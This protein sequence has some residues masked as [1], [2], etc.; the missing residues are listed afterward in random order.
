MLMNEENSKQSLGI[1]KNLKTN[2]LLNRQQQL[3]MQ[4]EMERNLLKLLI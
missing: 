1:E 2:F 4:E 3:D